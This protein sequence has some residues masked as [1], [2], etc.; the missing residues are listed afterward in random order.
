[1]IP[2]TQGSR[3]SFLYDD[4]MFESILDETCDRLHDKQVQFSL[5]R[6]DELELVLINLEHELAACCRLSPSEKQ[7]D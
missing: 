3:P 1:M 2:D 5:K 4:S 7:S 6:L